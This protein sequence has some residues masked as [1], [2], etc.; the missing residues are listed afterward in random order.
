MIAYVFTGANVNTYIDLRGVC[1]AQIFICV[2]A[3][4][5]TD[6]MVK[7][8]TRKWLR[9]GYVYSIYTTRLY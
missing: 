8:V 7:I 4:T 9:N 5:G 6:S 3:L 2:C 1:Y